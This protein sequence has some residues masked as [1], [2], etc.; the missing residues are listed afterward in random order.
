MSPT[1]VI[2]PESVVIARFSDCDPFG[3]LNNARYIDYFLNVREDHLAQHYDLH[4]YAHTQQ[5]QAGWVVTHT[6][7]SYLRPV[8]VVEEVVIRTCLVNFSDS[9]LTVEGAFLDKDS[10]KLKALCWMQFTYVDLQTGRTTE[11]TDD[12]K[13]LFSSVQ[14]A[15]EV[16]EGGFLMRVEGL[17]K[18]T[19]EAMIAQTA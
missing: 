18:N 9:L 8:K 3:H 6:E 12:L 7:I 5:H 10:R 16:F 1:H 4:L 19:T 13:R 11:H 17:R 2:L 14:I 15:P